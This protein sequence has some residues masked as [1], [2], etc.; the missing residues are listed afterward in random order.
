MNKIWNAARLI[1]SRPGGTDADAGR[2]W[3][4]PPGTLRL[5][6]RWIL[7]R[8][9]ETIE[10][11]TRELEALRP[12]EAMSAA[13]DFFWHELCDWYLE[14]AKRRTEGAD[15]AAVT[16]ILCRVFR[17]AM[18]LFHPV[19]PFVTEEVAARLPGGERMLAT[20]PWPAPGEFPAGGD[21]RDFDLVRRVVTAV[22]TL[23][24]EAC[25]PPAAQ[26][27]VRVRPQTR[28]EREILGRE[29]ATI[30]LL[31]RVAELD[32]DYDQETLRKALTLVVAGAQ[33]FLPV[34]G[35]V[36]VARER[37]RLG[38]E[39]GRLGQELAAVRAKLTKPSFL[40]KAPA[41]VVANEREKERRFAEKLS[42]LERN[43]AMLED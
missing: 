5:E 7:A 22:R 30:T 14:L 20:G 29:A 17:A 4:P 38:K 33:V 28:R 12:N 42:A 19:A 13:Y 39:I 27:A 11:V 32:L 40:D 3:P 15:G 9:R 21:E 2:A 36:D 37:T 24:A 16:Q 10:Q 18:A 35:L 41:E 26:V 34:E 43:L 31:A 6:D 25:V 1:A 23:R 8:T